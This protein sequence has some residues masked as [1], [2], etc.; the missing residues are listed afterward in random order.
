[1]DGKE[2]KNEVRTRNGLKGEE[3]IGDWRGVRREERSRRVTKSFK[4]PGHWLITRALIGSGDES[5]GTGVTF[6]LIDISPYN[7]VNSLFFP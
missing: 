4:M 6:L 3:A 2:E 7:Q 5:D 1:M